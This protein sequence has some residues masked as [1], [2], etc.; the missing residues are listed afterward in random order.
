MVEEVTMAKYASLALT[1]AAA[2]TTD[3]ATVARAELR[4]YGDSTWR[5][6]VPL[7]PLFN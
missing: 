3:T 4:I 7:R 2:A 6:A 1:L 5:G